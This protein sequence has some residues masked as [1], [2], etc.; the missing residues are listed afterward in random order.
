MPSFDAVSEVDKHQLMNSV[1]QANRLI[2]TRFDF[3]GMDAKFVL[4]GYNVTIWAEV[5]FQIEQ[6]M[7]V[8]KGALHKNK[9]DI[10]CLD[11]GDVKPLGKQVKQEVTVQTGLDSDTCRKIIKVIKEKKL[12]VQTQIQGD[13]VRVT[14]KKRDDLQQVMAV[15]RDSEIDMPLQFTNFRD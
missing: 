9:I 8:L 3:K 14:G 5:D 2:G 13:Q 4:E 7:D 15:L 1:D 6:M 11:A 12:K 10:S